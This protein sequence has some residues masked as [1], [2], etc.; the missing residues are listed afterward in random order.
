M[1]NVLPP[2]FN[3]S[4]LKINCAIFGQTSGIRSVWCHCHLNVQNVVVGHEDNVSALLQ[5][6]CQVVRTDPVEGFKR[7]LGPLSGEGWGG[8]SVCL[9]V[10]LSVCIF[11]VC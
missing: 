5:F 8:G 7:G 6:P 9:S 11:C 10:C 4:V 2:K 1:H 3:H